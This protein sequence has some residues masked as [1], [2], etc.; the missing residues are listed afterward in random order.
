MLSSFVKC[1]TLNGGLQKAQQQAIKKVFF[2]NVAAASAAANLT[3]VAPTRHAA[4][5]ALPPKIID[6]HHYFFD[7]KGN[8]FNAFLQPLG[9]SPYLPEQYKQDVIDPLHEMCV[10]VEGSVHIEMT[11]DGVNEAKWLQGMID[12]H[13]CDFV[14]AIV[15][16]CDLNSP[17]VEKKLNELRSITN[18]LRGVRWILDHDGGTTP[19]HTHVAT[20]PRL[21][22]L[23]GDNGDPLRGF[24]RGISMLE[25]FGLTFDLLCAPPQLYE[26]AKLFK[27]HAGVPVC[28]DHMGKPK[29]LLNKGLKSSAFNMDVW[30]RGM[31]AMADLPHAY[32]KL[33]MLG[34]AVPGWFGSPEREMFLRDLVW[35]TVDRFGPNRCMVG[36][37]YH[38]NGASSDS[39]GLSAI[40]P[41]TQEFYKALSSWF[42]DYSDDERE[43]LF[44]RTAK[45]FYRI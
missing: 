2:A 9:V 17:D 15:A 25:K 43:A 8:E 20:N 34:Y 7:P 18:K 41:T 23:N 11:D 39:D 6:A 4:K 5:K 3:D 37:N 42:E 21:D 45:T 12:A 32:V 38:L 35:R 19:M 16:N 26:A 29:T 14:K 24:E 44:Y 40:G 31:H 30:N 13:R 10:E 1:A 27:W 28:V 36:T 22:Y 33:S